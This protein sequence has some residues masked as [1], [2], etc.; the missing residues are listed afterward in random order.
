MRLVISY[1]LIPAKMMKKHWQWNGH[2]T[3]QEDAHMSSG[4]ILFKLKN[5]KFLFILND[6]KFVNISILRFNY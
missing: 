2:T 5:E 1:G 4:K 3:Q 6:F